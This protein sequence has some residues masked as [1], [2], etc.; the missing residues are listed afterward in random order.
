MDECWFAG[1]VSVTNSKQAERQIGGLIGFV[2]ASSSSTSITNCLNSGT[3]D[4]TSEKNSTVAAGGLVGRDNAGNVAISNSLN[5]GLIKKSSSTTKY[6]G[7][8]IGRSKTAS[9]TMPNT[10]ATEESC[11]VVNVSNLSPV[12][13]T[14]VSESTVISW[15]AATILTNLGGAWSKV[16]N[17]T[18][19]LTVF[20]NESDGRELSE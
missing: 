2:L 6:Y 9:L 11:S 5:V 15:D 17:R 4:V 7:P 12:P 1:T 14:S 13:F 10:Y 20:I 18:P 3:I 19:K 16:E 8:I